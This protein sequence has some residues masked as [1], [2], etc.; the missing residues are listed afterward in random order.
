MSCDCLLPNLFSHWYF[1]HSH[2]TISLQRKQSCAFWN[3]SLFLPKDLKIISKPKPKIR[4]FFSLTASLGYWEI[5]QVA[6]CSQQ[7]HNFSKNLD[8]CHSLCSACSNIQHI[9]LSGPTCKFTRWTQL[10]TS[11]AI[12]PLLCQLMLLH[13]VLSHLV[14]RF[15]S[16]GDNSPC[17]GRPSEMVCMPTVALTH[18]F[19]R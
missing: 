14:P 3:A 4:L 8:L 12:C 16:L 6:L 13:L 18:A 5:T 7:Y 1:V 2:H 9:P 15:E 11:L 17:M 10:L 19:C